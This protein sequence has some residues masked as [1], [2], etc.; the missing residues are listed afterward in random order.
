MVVF[1]LILSGL[2]L[3]QTTVATVADSS[4]K[5]LIAQLASPDGIERQSAAKQLLGMG[6]SVR[7]ELMAALDSAE[8]EIRAQLSRIL[9]DRP[10]VGA[11]DTPDVVALLS[12][13]GQRSVED[14]RRLV[15]NLAEMPDHSGRWAVVRILRFDPSAPVRWTAAGEL[16][17]RMDVDPL[18]EELRKMTDEARHTT[19]NAALAAA[20]GWA[21]R[22][23]Q[24]NRAEELLAHAID[25]E[26]QYPSS[27]G[28]EIDF[29]FR[30]LVDRKL[31]HGDV[32]S[33][34]LLLRELAGRQMEEQASATRH[35]VGEVFALD[36]EQ[37][38]V[39]GLLADAGRFIDFLPDSEVLYCLARAAR[40]CGCDTLAGATSLVAMAS[41]GSDAQR[42][43]EIG[44]FL[45]D[46]GWLT[47]AE[48]ELNLAVWLDRF[49]HN[50]AG[51]NAY[52]QLAKIAGQRN[53]DLAVAQ[54]LE[55]AMNAIGGG[56][57]E[58]RRTTAM[59]EQLPWSD[60]DAWAEIHWHYLRAARADHDL[61]A[62]QSHL[63]KLMDLNKLDQV[64]A[65][66]PDLATDLVPTLDDM[67]QHADADK[68]FNA[69][70][71]DLKKAISEQPDNAEA[72]N[73]LAWLSARCG[74]NLDEAIKYANDA[75]AA[76]PGNAAYLDTAAEANF[77]AGN[78][79]RAVELETAAL[80][81][82]PEDAFMIR[83]LRRFKAA[84]TTKP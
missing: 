9:L 71:T 3:A 69:A 30:W 29:A 75:V 23:R 48:L 78:S 70:Y 64:L 14:R 28:G 22:E 67:G 50:E 4:V 27:R 7:P 37:E 57:H 52:F 21:W 66:D 74:R 53:D 42:H 46:R 43:E 81:L 6:A 5:T 47:A 34:I 61:P 45:A 59:G 39:R 36:A 11:G 77:R 62:I 63:E 65:D 13:Y 44:A 56:V 40:G 49:G 72:K 55:A 35:T 8:P 31:E 83:Q 33:A 41:G 82:R 16:R 32:N 26:R 60:A 10:W 2:S 79:R 19:H 73:N 1:L 24:P 51:V 76:S 80:Q 38:N 20:V 84:A 68:C 25:V 15:L 58:M 54:D 17:R 12:D 18:G